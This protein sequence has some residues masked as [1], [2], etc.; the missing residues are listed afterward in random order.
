MNPDS[1]RTPISTSRRFGMPISISDLLHPDGLADSLDLLESIVVELDGALPVQPQSN[2]VWRY[3]FSG[4]GDHCT[5]VSARKEGRL[6]TIS[7][8]STEFIRDLDVTLRTEYQQRL[9]NAGPKVTSVATLIISFLE[10]YPGL[11]RT[12]PHRWWR[13]GAFTDPQAQRD[14]AEVLAVCTHDH[15]NNVEWLL[16][17]TALK[18]R[19]N[20]TFCDWLADQRASY[21]VFRQI[22]QLESLSQFQAEL[23]RQNHLQIQYVRDGTFL[24]QWHVQDC[25][26]LRAEASSCE[27]YRYEQGGTGYKCWIDALTAAISARKT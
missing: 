19:T 21:H 11:A 13:S 3:A 4:P 2:E 16:L 7:G 12:P 17:Q 8:T 15:L 24:W 18:E 27:C 5:F 20:G 10:R 1:K 14:L 9:A 22:W 23:Q 6:A 25:P 26:M